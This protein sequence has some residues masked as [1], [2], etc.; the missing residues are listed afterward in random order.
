MIKH[1]PCDDDVEMSNFPSAANEAKDQAIWVNW[2][3]V[4]YLSTRDPLKRFKN[5][6]NL[7]YVVRPQTKNFSVSNLSPFYM[8]VKNYVS[9]IAKYYELSCSTSLRIIIIIVTLFYYMY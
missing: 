6:K 1:D 4:F 9:D 3:G 7:N 5:A 8:E 2:S